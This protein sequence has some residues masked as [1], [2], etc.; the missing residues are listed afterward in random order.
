[1]FG[2][3]LLSRRFTHTSS[4]TAEKYLRQTW[5]VITQALKEHGISC[6]LDLVSLYFTRIM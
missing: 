5:P 1:M 6:V 3:L 2:V 4:Q